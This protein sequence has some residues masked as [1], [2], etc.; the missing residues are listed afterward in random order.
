MVEYLV[1]VRLHTFQLDQQPAHFF[2]LSAIAPMGAFVLTLILAARID[3]WE[4]RIVALA[5][6]AVLAAIWS[7]W[8]LDKRARLSIAEGIGRIRVVARFG[9]P[10]V[11]TSATS[12]IV[13]FTD[14]FIVA[15]RVAL[16]D[17]GVYTVAYALG[18]GVS[19]AHDGVARYFVSRLPGSVETEV[20]SQAAARF[21]YVYTAVAVLSIPVLIPVAL[22][23]LNLLASDAFADA[24][25]LLIWLIPAQ[26]LAGVARYLRDILY[27]ERRTGQRAVLS[28]GEA[29]FNVALTWFLVGALGTVGAFDRNA[30]HVFRSS[31]RYVRPHA[32]L[33]TLSPSFTR[34][35]FR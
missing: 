30:G 25:D 4:S 19:S 16:A 8:S 31:D 26:T 17:A 34:I 33:A 5:V 11:V 2:A 3:G 13:G 32:T 6:V 28:T 35:R 27:V 7:A 24:S 23:G 20:G 1:A 9:A 21:A 15:E 10:L 22:V 18:M 29:L 12:W 14:R